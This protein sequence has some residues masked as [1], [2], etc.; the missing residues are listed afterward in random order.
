VKK[1]IS[2]VVILIIIL[3]VGVHSP[4]NLG[5][6]NPTIQYKIVDGKPPIDFRAPAALSGGKNGD[7]VIPLVPAF[8]WKYGC[9][10]T[11][12]SMF[13]SYYD[14]IGYT[15]FYEG[16]L[17]NGVKI[18]TDDLWINQKRSMNIID[19]VNGASPICATQKGIE[20]RT[21]NGHVNDYWGQPNP[22]IIGGWQEHNSDCT[23]DYMGTNQNKYGCLN[24]NAGATAFYFGW[25]GNDYGLRINDNQNPIVYTEDGTWTRDGCHGMKLFTETKGYSVLSNYSQYIEELSDPNH[26]DLNRG[27]TFD[28]Y[29]NEIDNFRPVLIQVSGHTMLGYGYNKL[30]RE[31]VLRDTWDHEQ[32]YMLWGGSYSGMQHLAV[33]VLNLQP[34]N[35]ANILSATAISPT[36]I[37]LRWLPIQGAI[38]YKIEMRTDSTAWG[39]KAF[40]NGNTNNYLVTGLVPNTKYYFRVTALTKV[41]GTYDPYMNE[42]FAT[43]WFP[44]PKTPIPAAPVNGYM[45]TNPFQTFTFAYNPAIGEPNMNLSYDIQISRE[46]SFN[47]P[48]MIAY[49]SYGNYGQVL[50]IPAYWLNLSWNTL[51]YWRVRAR[52]ENGYAFG[53]SPWTAPWILRTG[54]GP[55]PSKPEINLQYMNSNYANNT[56]EFNIYFYST[57]FVKPEGVIIEQSANGGPFAQIRR[58]VP[59]QFGVAIPSSSLTPNTNYAFRVKFFNCAQFSEYSAPAYFT[60]PPPP[61]PI[62]VLKSPSNNSQFSGDYVEVYPSTNWTNIN[63]YEVWFSEMSDSSSYTPLYS[64]E[65]VNGVFRFYVPAGLQSSKRY[66]NAE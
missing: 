65:A 50:N 35:T 30:T 52:N 7:V 66:G 3:F 63:Y 36:Q 57:D 62:P 9:S 11:S 27:Y 15:R 28:E 60:S 64:R 43:T 20:G 4:V 22:Y 54:C 25:L 41:G 49:E 6:T 21:T 38:S 32:H 46:P 44:T 48:S 39:L 47:N 29:C 40:V 2:V 53:L 1:I 24:G 51:Y 59:V 61:P 12:A 10:A 23:A 58:F 17:Y 18:Y 13:F 37:M 5:I 56:Y 45:I 26:Q 14:N 16:S 19:Y 31:V 42:A 34:D 33:T 55:K 8:K